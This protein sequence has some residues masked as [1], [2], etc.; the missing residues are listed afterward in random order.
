VNR[1]RL[2]PSRREVAAVA[3][4][5]IVAAAVVLVLVIWAPRWWGGDRGPSP[6]RVIEA[7]TDAEPTYSLFADAVA[8]R[9]HVLVDT[10]AIDPESVRLDARVTPFRL[11]SQRRR[12]QTLGEHAAAVDFELAVQCVSLSCLRAAGVVDE[13]GVVRP[14]P[15]AVR[16]GRI[17][18]VRAD[19]FSASESIEWP[20]L[21]VHTR[22]TPAEARTGEPRTGA[23]PTPRASYSVSPDLL[24]GLLIGAGVLLAVVGGLLLAA[25][26]RGKPIPIRLRIPA[27][28]TP[29]DRAL[30]LVRDASSKDDTIE[31][32]RAL[33]RL[34]VELRR[35]EEPELAQEAGRL[36]W[37][38][39][40]PSPAAVEQLAQDVSSSVNGR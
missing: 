10:G 1:L 3:V 20:R 25:A 8:L 27:H 4:A 24:A 18:Y 6:S 7:T 29:L 30:A 14:T 40:R 19:G 34:A 12:I 22:L 15:I 11:I 17:H 39:D 26:V 36:A 13:D 38:V 21:V 2:R 33:E 5:G 28:L 9:A 32:R 37:S 23:F 31:G 16:P 35:R